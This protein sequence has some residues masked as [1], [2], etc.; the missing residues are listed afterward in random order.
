MHFTI[1]RGIP[2]FILHPTFGEETSYAQS[3]LS[4]GN[5]SYTLTHMFKVSACS[6]GMHAPTLLIFQHTPLAYLAHVH[7]TKVWFFIFLFKD[8]GLDI[9]RCAH[10]HSEP[11]FHT[12]LSPAEC[13]WY[14]LGGC[15]LCKDPYYP[16]DVCHA[17]HAVLEKWVENGGFNPEHMADADYSC[18]TAIL[19]M[20][21]PDSSTEWYREHGDQVDCLPMRSTAWTDVLHVPKLI[22]YIR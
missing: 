21:T 18:S 20:L 22:K 3:T 11:T 6:L 15:S 16:A 12:Y 8:G 2:K 13:G 7:M 9:W 4:T 1:R 19:L 5:T 10:H 17:T 14:S